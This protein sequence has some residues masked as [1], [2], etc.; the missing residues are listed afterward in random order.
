MRFVRLWDSTSLGGSQWISGCDWD[1]VVINI[2][3]VRLPPCQW[4]KVGLSAAKWLIKKSVNKHFVSVFLL[5][6]STSKQISTV[7][8][9]VFPDQYS[10]MITIRTIRQL[11]WTDTKAASENLIISFL[12]NNK[13][14]QRL[15]WKL[16]LFLSTTYLRFLLI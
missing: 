2:E 5:S 9:A 4:P 16:I 11:Q 15:T 8:L 6:F 3:W 7:A 1:S 12:E 13:L 14:Q 10:R